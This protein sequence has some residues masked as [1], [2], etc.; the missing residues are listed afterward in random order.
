VDDD[1]DWAVMKYWY[2]ELKM[3]VPDASSMQRQ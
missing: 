1:V 3:T 2:P